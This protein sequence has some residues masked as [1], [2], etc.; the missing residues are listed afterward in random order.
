VSFNVKVL[1]NGAMP[2][3][4]ILSDDAARKNER[5]KRQLEDMRGREK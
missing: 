4:G 2:E 1:S 3:E 5:E